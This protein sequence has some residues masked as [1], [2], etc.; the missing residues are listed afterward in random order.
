M[1]TNAFV[2][3]LASN[4][5]AVRENALATLKKFLSSKEKA[6]KLDSNELNK[7]WKGLFYT[8]WFCDRPRPQQRLA[9]ELAGLFSESI[10]DEQFYKFVESFWKIMI[11]EWRDL[12][13]WRTDK[14]LMLMRYVIRECFARIKKSNWNEDK[15]ELYLDALKS[16]ILKDD[17]KT[18]RAITYH[19]IDVWVDELERVIF[20]E[21]DESEESEESDDEE[22]EEDKHSKKIEERKELI[23]TEKIPFDALLAPMKELSGKGNFAPLVKK[24]RMEVLEDERLLELDIDTS[25]PQEDAEGEEEDGEENDGSDGE[26]YEEEEEFKGF[27]L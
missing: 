4:K 8:M 6:T 21:E 20:G 7:L 10:I 19:I 12:D 3:Q 17:V 1:K 18:P 11:N 2:R 9:N 15:L 22:S 16:V 13:K 23:E 5:R 14:F 26:E 24:I 27:S 25:L